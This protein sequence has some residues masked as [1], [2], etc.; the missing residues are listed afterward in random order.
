MSKIEVLT[1]PDERL[2]WQ[3]NRETPGSMVVVTSYQHIVDDAISIIPP[4]A[5]PALLAALLEDAGAVKVRIQHPRGCD[6]YHISAL[7]GES[8]PESVIKQGHLDDGYIWLLSIP[9]D[10][11]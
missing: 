9:E 3:E 10:T 8:V 4:R 7:P 6:Y 5:K 11:L 1:V 2:E